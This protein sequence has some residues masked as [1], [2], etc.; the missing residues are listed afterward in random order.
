[1]TVSFGGRA[2]SIWN[3]DWRSPRAGFLAGG[4]CELSGLRWKQLGFMG[5]LYGTFCKQETSS[6]GCWSRRSASAGTRTQN[7][8]E[9]QG[10]DCRSAAA[11]HAEGELPTA[12]ADSAL[13]RPDPHPS[14][15]PAD[16]GGLRQSHA[17]ALGRRQP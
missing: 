16:D 7:R 1:M 17:K 5:N 12:A 2:V 9:G 6:I 3:Y 8:P 10:M 15:N 14:Q 13:A 11:W 4:G